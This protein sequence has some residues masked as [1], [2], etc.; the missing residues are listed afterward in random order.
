MTQLTDHTSHIVR[1]GDRVTIQFATRVIQAEVIEDLG[2]IGAGGRQLVRV[3]ALE[4]TD[5]EY[6]E[7]ELAAEEL[8]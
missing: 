5:G 2:G 6:E 1:V 7:F 8:N 4:P 3:R